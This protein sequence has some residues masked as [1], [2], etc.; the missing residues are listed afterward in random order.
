[1][2]VVAIAMQKGGV[3][4]STLTRSLAEAASHSGLAVLVLD[5]DPQQS[6]EQWS[7]RREA[8]DLPVRFV[9]E[10]DL[11]PTLE[12]VRD[13][14]CDLVFIDTPPARSSEAPAAVEAADLVL[15]PCTPDIEAFEQLPRTARLARTTGKKAF[16]VLNMAT[17]NSMSDVNAAQAVS[18]RTKVDM[19]PVVIF[20]RKI[21]R[22]A[23]L[24]G[25][26]ARE[27]DQAA[28]GSTEIARLWDWLSV[29][30]QICTPAIV[31]DGSAAA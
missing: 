18:E 3:G 22:E 5:M 7:R 23:A 30:L 8:K 28:K 14:G 20:R 21:H 10:L 27:V 29:E 19:A 15:V 1:M 9:T 31:Q 4:K 25:R 17:P 13:A 16:V 6:V 11:E 12:R 26:S 2:K 24:A